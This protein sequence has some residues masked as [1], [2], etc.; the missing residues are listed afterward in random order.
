MLEDKIAAALGLLDDVERGLAAAR[1]RATALAD[2]IHPQLD[3]EAF[4]A[5]LKRPYALI[6]KKA[7]EWYCIVPKFIDFSVGWLEM[8]TESHNIFLINRFTLWLGTV[9]DEIRRATGIEAPEGDFAVE[10]G[11]LKFKKGDRKILEAGKLKLH[12]SKIGETS[13]R[14]TRGREFQLI[15]DLIDEGH[16]P[17][18]PKPVAPED[19]RPTQLLFTQDGKYQFQDDAYHKF[20]KLGAVGIYWMTGAGKSFFTMRCADSLVGPKLLVVPTRT[21]VDQ[22]RDYFRQYAPRLLREVE[23]ITYQAYHKV[24]NRE[25]V[26]VVFDECHRL[27]S[28]TFSRLATL[29]AK[30]RIGLSASPYRED[31]RTS[32]IFALTG[33]PIGMDWKDLMK[34]LGKE[35]HAVN[36]HVVRDDAAKL[37]KAHQLV[38]PGRK[39][40]VFCDS[41][42]LG[43]RCAKKLGVEF[44]HG[45]TSRRMEKAREQT[46]FVASRVMDLGVSLKDLEHIV[47]IDFLYGSRQQEVQRTG[48]LLHSLKGAQH[49]ILMTKEELDLYG[50]RLHALVERGFKVNV[51]A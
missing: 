44:I 7:D 36:V 33:F 35:Y 14:I 43:D 47:E 32:Y 29:K 17:F 26:L 34:I 50:K 18:K 41:L 39:T 20:L 6:R 48:R 19:L 12:L 46:V 21:L 8:A 15:A 31:G 3:R 22:W 4:A 10:D 16:L 42:T 51:H 25:F 24:Q 13:A 40:I 1:T 2:E 38:A 37:V 28:N 23:I 5:F 45:G 9:S 27:P 11:E 30:Y 49:D